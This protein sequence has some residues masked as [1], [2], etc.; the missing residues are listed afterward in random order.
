[1]ASLAELLAG[2][3]LLRVEV[4][5]GGGGPRHPPGLLVKGEGGVENVGPGGGELLL[6]L[7]VL[8]LWQSIPTAALDDD[9]F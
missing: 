6:L 4:G 2:P 5:G 3:D 8:P 1:M 9:S 7:D